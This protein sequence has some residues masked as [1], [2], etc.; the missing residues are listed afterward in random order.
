[1]ADK[2]KSVGVVIHYYPKIS[3]GIVKLSGSLKTGDK[4]KF[5]GS[6][7]DFEQSVGDIEVDHE[8]IEEGKK[9]QE[10]GIKVDEKVKK[11]DKVYLVE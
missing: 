3:V 7:T 5:E 2:Q 11:K 4:V 9:G 1:M 6:S 10:V 8:K